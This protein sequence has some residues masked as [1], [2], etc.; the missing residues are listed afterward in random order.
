M[1]SLLLYDVSVPAINQHLKRIFGDQELAREATI[2]KYL[3]VQ[4]EGKRQVQCEVDHYSLRAII[5]VGFKKLTMKVTSIK[6]L[7][8][9]EP[10]EEGLPETPPDTTS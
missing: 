9:I 4:A 3:I 6:T 5:A 1:R 10:E 8:A 2:K 7:Q